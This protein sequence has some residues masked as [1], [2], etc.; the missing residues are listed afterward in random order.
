M[1]QNIDAGHTN[2]EYCLQWTQ[3]ILVETIMGRQVYT[4]VIQQTYLHWWMPFPVVFLLN[5]SSVKRS[6]MSQL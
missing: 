5:Y 2:G 3:P 6:M 4:N 1:A